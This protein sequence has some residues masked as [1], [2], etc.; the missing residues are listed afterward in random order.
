MSKTVKKLAIL[1]AVLFSLPAFALDRDQLIEAGNL[2]K[3][4]EKTDTGR[5]NLKADPEANIYLEIN[6][7]R[8]WLPHPKDMPS[9]L[10][11]HLEQLL[12][13]NDANLSRKIDQAL[14]IR[15]EGKAK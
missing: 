3:E 2:A 9:E 4:R 14:R 13:A 1:A 11:W 6:Y 12:A 5:I 15:I 7:C 10:R 8:I